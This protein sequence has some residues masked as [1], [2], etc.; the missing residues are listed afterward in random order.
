[1][2]ETRVALEAREAHLH[3]THHRVRNNLQPIVS[4]LRLQ[5]DAHAG[6]ALTALQEAKRR[7]L[8]IS[9][10]E[11]SCEVDLGGERLPPGA[12][13]PIALIVNELSQ[14]ACLHGRGPDG[15]V[16]LSIGLSRSLDGQRTLAVRDAGPGFAAAAPVGRPSGLGLPLVSALAAQL[17]G[18]L[19]TENDGGAVVRIRF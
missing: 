9:A 18:T 6:T 1:M 10:V 12:A 7:V 8:A 14:N 15:R 3:E 19:E 4:L 11:D 5:S 17:G 2:D 13:A 16:V